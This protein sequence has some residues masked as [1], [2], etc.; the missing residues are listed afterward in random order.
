MKKWRN[1]TEFGMNNSVKSQ[2]IPAFFYMPERKSC[3]VLHFLIKVIAE[4]AKISLSYQRL[5]SLLLQ[6]LFYEGY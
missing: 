1:I 3:Y 6:A 2:Y 4:M 5:K